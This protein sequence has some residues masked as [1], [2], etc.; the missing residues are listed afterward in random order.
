MSKEKSKKESV[1]VSDDHKWP[2]ERIEMLT[3][4]FPNEGSACFKILNESFRSYPRITALEVNR[5]ARQ[6]EI[7]FCQKSH[8]EKVRRASLRF[9]IRGKEKNLRLQ[10]VRFKKAS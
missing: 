3:D 10:E 2:P 1:W 8:D 4:L 5:K 9:A 6:L 7:E